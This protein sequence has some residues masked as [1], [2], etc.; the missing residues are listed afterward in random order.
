MLGAVQSSNAL[1]SRSTA[2]TARD[3]D[4]IIGS[5]TEVRIKTNEAH[6]QGDVIAYSSEI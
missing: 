4:I 1:Y 2:G 3:F 6:F 5:T